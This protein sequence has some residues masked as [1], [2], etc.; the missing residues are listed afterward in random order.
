MHD[1]CDLICQLGK[2]LVRVLLSVPSPTTNLPTFSFNR[3]PLKMIPIE[4]PEYFLNY[5]VISSCHDIQILNF[6][7]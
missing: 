1:N 6:F 4:I 3:K 7:N 5:H 2:N